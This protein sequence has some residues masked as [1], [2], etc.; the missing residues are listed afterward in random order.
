MELIEKY[1]ME[2]LSLKGYY[3]LLKFIYA[4]LLR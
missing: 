3:F 4:I 1:R 2:R